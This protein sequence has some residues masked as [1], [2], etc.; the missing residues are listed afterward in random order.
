ML[1]R[2]TQAHSSRSQLGIWA[3]LWLHF[4]ISIYTGD[5]GNP[6][7][8]SFLERERGEGKEKDR[9]RNINVWLPLTCPPTGDLAR[10][11]DC[12][13]V[14]EWHMCPD[15][16]LNQLPFGSKARA[17]STESHQPGC[18]TYSLNMVF[19]IV[20]AGKADRT[21]V[22]QVVLHEC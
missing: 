6:Y 16:E 12:S 15:W 19:S 8:L 14:L 3:A 11:P 4:L 13:P 20:T 7:S 9:E 1:S 10:S 22:T 17:P 21:S 2:R 18:N 5:T